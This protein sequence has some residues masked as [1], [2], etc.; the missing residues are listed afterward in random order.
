VASGLED[1]AAKGRL[2]V[3]MQPAGVGLS[4]RT[5]G[6]VLAVAPVEATAETAAANP[7]DVLA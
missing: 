5:K 6:S 4:L 7:A 2:K 1:V 3:I